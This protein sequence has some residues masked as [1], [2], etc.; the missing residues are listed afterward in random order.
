MGPFVLILIRSKRDLRIEHESQMTAVRCKH[1]QSPGDPTNVNANV[2]GNAK[3]SFHS[4][5]VFLEFFLGYALRKFSACVNSHSQMAHVHFSHARV[6]L[7]NAQIEI[8]K[9]PKTIAVRKKIY[10][11]LAITFGFDNLRRLNSDLFC[12]RV[13]VW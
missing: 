9:N 4:L 13:R 7:H 8:Y 12:V 11:C 3:L 1:Q 10:K 6:I 5:G 2:N